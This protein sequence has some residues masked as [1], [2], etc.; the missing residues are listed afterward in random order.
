M[1]R[2]AC[3]KALPRPPWDLG[4]RPSAKTFSDDTYRDILEQENEQLRHLTRELQTQ[5][6]ELQSREA[7]RRWSDERALQLREEIRRRD[8]LIAEITKTII[9]QFQK[10]KDCTED[11]SEEITIYSCFDTDC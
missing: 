2:R 1:A 8:S 4:P 6:K 5:L 9:D 11:N 10:Y 7:D 3:D